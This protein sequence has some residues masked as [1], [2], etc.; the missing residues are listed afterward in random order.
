VLVLVGSEPMQFSAVCAQCGARE[1]PITGA[2]QE[3]VRHLTRL[4]WRLDERYTKTALCPSC[5]GPPSV[6]PAARVA[7]DPTR[8]S[9]CEDAVLRCIVCEVE[10]A[11][12]EAI[13]CRG[14]F[15]H[16]HARCATQRLARFV[17]PEQ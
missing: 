17:L 15:G 5:A 12:D 7:A 11:L 2:R 6:F 10:F 13:S 8:C 14:T 9:E 4:S 3:A 1:G 16:A